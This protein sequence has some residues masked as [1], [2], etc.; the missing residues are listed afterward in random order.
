MISSLEYYKVFYYVGKYKSFSKAAEKLCISQPA[1]SQTIKMLESELACQLF[2]RTSKG[3]KLT[4]EGMVL[5][6]YVKSGIEQFL[7][8]EDKIKKMRDLDKGEI[9]IGASD[10][11]LQFYLLPFLEKFHKLYPDIKVKVTNAT[12]P[13]TL[14]NLYSGKIDFGVVSE[15][16]SVKSSVKKVKVREI[17]DTFVAGSL[18][19]HLKGKKLDLKILEELPVICL[20]ENSSTRRYLDNF[21]LENDVV[22]KPEFELA[23]SDM[24]VQFAFRNL[25]I[26]CVMKGF[27]EEQIKNGGLFELE[28]TKNIPKR[29]FCLIYN[30]T[31]PI[32]IASN[33]LLNIMG[34]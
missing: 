16:F 34:F 1:I 12:T 18:F 30:H 15:P 4:P 26:G 8:G 25:G 28:F 3:V 5:S 11:T 6:E 9:H 29:H 20:E 27:A 7:M 19:Q 2:F 33:Q 21:L 17:E 24:I 14:E 13:E 23:T 31:E 22:L 32:S 10:M